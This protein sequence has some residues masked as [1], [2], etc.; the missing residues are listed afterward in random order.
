MTSVINFINTGTGANA[1]NGDSLRTAFNKIN[2]N[3]VDLENSYVQSGV[4]SFNGTGGRITFTATEIAQVL[5]YVPYSS[6]NPAQYVTAAAVANLA[7]LSYL[8][9]T[10]VTTSTILNY[11]TLA[12]VNSNLAQY[13]SLDFIAA[14][15]YIT[16]LSLPTFLSSYATQIYVNQ[17]GF[18][19]SSTVNLYVNTGNSDLLPKVNN[20]YTI[21]DLGFRWKDLYLSNSIDLNNYILTVNTTTGILQINGIGLT[22]NFK[23]DNS[24]IYNNNV[25]FDIRA[26]KREIGGNSTAGLHIPSD[27]DAGT[28]PVFLYNTGSGVILGG[29]VTSVQID[30]STIN[31]VSVIGN[32][33]LPLTFVD[34]NLASYPRMEFAFIAGNSNPDVS[35]E[36]LLYTGTA[37]TS[38]ARGSTTQLRPMFIRGNNIWLRSQENN[39]PEVTMMGI[40]PDGIW[41]GTDSAAS[42]ILP[43]TRGNTGTTFINNGDGTVSWS[44]QTLGYTNINSNN[45][46]FTTATITKSFKLGTDGLRFNDNSIMTT[47]YGN[48]QVAD[49]LPSYSGALSVGYIAGLGTN[50][51]IISNG[52][53]WAFSATGVLSLP[54][55]GQIGELYGNGVDIRANPSGYVKL[56]SNS[57]NNYLKIDNLGAY[58]FATNN[59]WTFGTDG[60]LTFPDTSVQATAFTGTV[61]YSNITGA[62]SLVNKTTGS[63]T[64]ATGANTVSITVPLNGNYQMWVNGNIPNGIVE[65]NA[66]VNVSNPNVPAI[67]SQYAWYYATGNALVLTAIP[68]QIVGTVGVISSSTGYLG[69]TADVFTFGITN[70]SGS[71]QVIKWGY[72]TL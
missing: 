11:A 55:G 1:G 67:G 8:N 27:I 68:N 47:A 48:Q 45:A 16:N 50:V 60:T 39:T 24:D 70:N 41:I 56:V 38:Y 34:S 32:V 31:G 57:G 52:L 19:T 15:N 23:F 10:F 12:Y 22:G 44:T 58:V 9:S 62:P 72:T 14:Q 65:W 33:K 7:D 30:N 2:Q 20:A 17:Q 71:S 18:L 64:L 46:V 63:W 69:N 40:T 28:D 35:P 59:L 49:Y 26:T 43:K 5:G 66:T 61:A 25:S 13:A 4:A 36:Y 51:D 54:D 21:G 29:K 53:K 6:L 42:Y 37:I 3:F